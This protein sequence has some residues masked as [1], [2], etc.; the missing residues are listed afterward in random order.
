MSAQITTEQVWQQVQLL[1]HG[2]DKQIADADRWLKDYQRTEG[3][4]ASLEQ[5]LHT[6]GLNEETLFFAANTLKSKIV[7]GDL[8]QLDA[9]AQEALGGSLMAHIYKFRNGPMTVRKQLCLA[10]SSYAGEFDKIRSNIVEEVCKAMGSS[11]DTMPVLLDLLTL[12]G[13]EAARVQEDSIDL[14]PDQHHHLY[15]SACQSALAVLNFTH[16]C[17]SSLQ[18]DG[19]QAKQGK[20]QVMTCFCRWLRFGTVPAEQMVQSPIVHAALPAIQDADLCEAASDLLCELAYISRE[21]P[22]GLPIFQMLTAALETFEGLVKKALHEE[23]DILGRSITRVVVEMGESYAPILA[24]ASPDAVRMINLICLCAS[25]PDRRIASIT[26]GFWY[27]L[28]EAMKD[29][30]QDTRL[31]CVEAMDAPLSQLMIVLVRAA[32]FPEEH[33]EWKE[34]EQ[35][36]FRNF[37]LE[38][39]FD[40]V[41]DLCSMLGSLRCLKI[42][43][44]ELQKSVQSCSWNEDGWR[45]VEGCLFTVRVLARHV[46]TDENEVVPALLSLYTHLPEHQRVRQAFTVVIAKFSPW[47]NSHPEALRPLLEYV[48]RG[49][50]PSKTG[51]LAA[52]SLQ[53]LCDDCAEHM[54]G[55]ANLEGLMQIYNNIDS[56]ELPQQEKILEGFGAV[57][58][59]IPSEQIAHMLSIVS[60]PPIRD[61]MAALERHDKTRVSMQIKKLKTLLKGGVSACDDRSGRRKSCD[62][63]VLAKAWAASFANAWPMFEQSIILFGQDE[64]LME[65]VCRCIRSAI[66]AIGLEFKAF[67]SPFATSAVNAYIKHPLS[68]ILYAVTTVVSFFGKYQEFVGPL[69]EMLAALSA[70]TFQVFSSGEAFVN[71]P[72]IVTEYF[73]MMERAVRRFPQVVYN[74]PL[75]ENA[76]SCGVASLYTKLE[77]REAIRAILSFFENVVLSDANKENHELCRADR[78]AA[79]IFL[80]GQGPGPCGT[81]P[82]PRGQSMVQALMYAI[83]TKPSVVVE[84]VATILYDLGRFMPNQ[85]MEW[86]MAGIAVVP[87]N[88]L[89]QSAK[90]MFVKDLPNARDIPALKGIVRQLY[91]NCKTS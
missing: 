53:E 18:G 36:E 17:F 11:P 79:M 3:A 78:E 26:F 23:D 22:K 88:I 16:Q 25:N 57:L 35:D 43:L 84:P 87:G 65:D 15:T 52:E 28:S 49:L 64:S 2:H 76:L 70:R 74:S 19:A 71:S 45:A 5:L 20:G 6:E 72:D 68:C 44:P 12:L 41:L 1:Y 56:L 31:K 62:K 32:T 4:W 39:L 90:D 40:A 27:R 81:S 67:L 9:K 46:S 86:V 34:N 83:T 66:Q 29:F 85:R 55:N 58:A 24:Q 60:S 77:H 91:R 10:F 82:Q 61:G 80:V 48:V 21:M 13:E 63:E 69:S 14:P 89:S 51:T 38:A 37:R 7:R 33:E 59:R 54:A 50:G 47:L 75:G 8:E 42:V 73:E 30:P